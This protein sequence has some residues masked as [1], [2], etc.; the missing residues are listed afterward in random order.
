MSKQKKTDYGT[1]AISK[2]EK[3]IK[4]TDRVPAQIGTT[5]GFRYQIKGKPKEGRVEFVVKVIIPK[6]GL[7][8]PKTGKTFHT[9][10]FLKKKVKIDK[11]HHEFLTFEE[12]WD[13]VPGK[14]EI[15]IW[16]EGKKVAEKTFT[17]YKP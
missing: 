3:L 10:T 5:F 7:T 17:V 4:Q 2:V 1:S 11:I 15:Q 16:H 9:L 14:W 12:K 13:L 6:P 8:N